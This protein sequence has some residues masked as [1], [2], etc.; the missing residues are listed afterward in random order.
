MSLE[1]NELWK[2]PEKEKQ[3]KTRTKRRMCP[4]LFLLLNDFNN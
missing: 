4:L 2:K 3:N 1:E